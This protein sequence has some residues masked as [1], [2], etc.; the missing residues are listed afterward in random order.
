VNGSRRLESCL[1]RLIDSAIFVRPSQFSARIL[2]KYTSLQTPVG[3]SW[4]HFSLIPSNC[5][6]FVCPKSTTTN[7]RF[8]III[9]QPWTKPLFCPTHETPCRPSGHH[10]WTPL[11]A[12]NAPPGPSP[13]RARSLLRQPRRKR[14]EGGWGS[15]RPATCGWWVEW[16]DL[17]VAYVLV[18]FG[19][20]WMDLG[21][22][23]YEL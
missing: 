14:R 10:L 2:V 1:D 22:M 12:P 3:R 16:I 17:G 20:F 18:V 19:C 15:C 13:T 8:P 9:N 4:V 7:Q 5:P 11:P 21:L 6:S 23:Y